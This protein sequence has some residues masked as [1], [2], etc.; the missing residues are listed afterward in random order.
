MAG[1]KHAAGSRSSHDD[2]RETKR[3]AGVP[4]VLVQR[5]GVEMELKE[6]EHLA[7]DVFVTYGKMRAV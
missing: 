2:R 4:V 5:I 7:H 1:K 6:D 3:P